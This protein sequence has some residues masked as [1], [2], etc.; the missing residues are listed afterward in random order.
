MS[1]L[2]NP[3][4]HTLDVS[5]LTDTV[6]T[7]VIASSTHNGG[8]KLALVSTLDNGNNIVTNVHVMSNT[9]HN[10]GSNPAVLYAGT[11]LTEAIEAYNSLP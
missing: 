2:L 1:Q 4:W 5:D 3:K 7:N 8:K 9:N 10:S 11:N 6:F